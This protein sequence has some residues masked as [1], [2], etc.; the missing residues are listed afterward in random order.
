MTHIYSEILLSQTINPNLLNQKDN[1]GDTVF[2]VACKLSNY[3]LVNKLLTYYSS[4]IDFS[5]YSHRYCPSL[6]IAF[7]NRDYK[8]LTLLLEFN[9]H[10]N[11]I[12]TGS[13][14]NIALILIEA[15]YHQELEMV[16]IL[17]S[18]CSVDDITNVSNYIFKDNCFMMACRK[19][20]VDIA[21]YILNLP[22]IDKI[23]NLIFLTDFIRDSPLIIACS[24]TNV[25]SIKFLLEQYR[26]LNIDFVNHQ[27]NFGNS[28]L[29]IACHNACHNSNH[30]ENLEIIKLLLD[31]GANTN[32]KNNQGDTPLTL[33]CQYSN[34]SIITEI[35]NLLIKYGTN[36]NITNNNG[37]N[38]LM[39][40]CKYSKNFD[41][42]K[43]LLEHHAHINNQN[44][45]G[46]TALIF[47]SQSSSSR[48][49]KLFLNYIS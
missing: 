9:K 34:N 13:I 7:T 27:N 31:N 42:I 19:N 48:N 47:L 5:Y 1:N 32:I 18:Y 41:V 39:L 35:I 10:N 28:A 11:N 36:I 17:S 23:K 3:E 4:H 6:F 12:I 26:N 33:I 44:N 43:L 21:D 45:Y 46:D 24:N 25:S 30:K 8:M 20:N 40:I 22:D 29:Y 2:I 15:C 49:L 16:K 37:D 38:A 14:S